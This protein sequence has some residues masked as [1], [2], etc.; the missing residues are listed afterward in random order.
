MVVEARLLELGGDPARQAIR[1]LKQSGLKTE[2]AF[3][4]YFQLEGDAYQVD[5]RLID[6]LS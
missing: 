5:L 6:M 3:A 1:R 4:R 2:P